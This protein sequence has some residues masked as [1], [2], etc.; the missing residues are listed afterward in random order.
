MVLAGFGGWE[1][2][3]PPPSMTQQ[4]HQNHR[5]QGTNVMKIVLTFKPRVR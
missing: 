5:G 2:E 1:G 4:T 3:T